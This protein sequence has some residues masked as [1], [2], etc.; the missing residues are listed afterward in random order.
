MKNLKAKIM[1]FIKLKL[2]Q[3]SLY[4]VHTRTFL[5]LMINVLLIRNIDT[6]KC[7]FISQCTY[8]SCMQMATLMCLDAI[9]DS[10]SFATLD[11]TVHRIIQE[12]KVEEDRDKHQH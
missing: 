11:S 7:L 10:A 12:L 1:Q 8:I 6:G 5:I 3:P 9:N 2:L 4:E